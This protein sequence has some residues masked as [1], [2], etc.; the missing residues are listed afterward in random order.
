MSKLIATVALAA[1]IAMP[2]QGGVAVPS[3]TRNEPAIAVARPSVV[4]IELTYTG[5]VRD[6]VTGALRD[7]APVVFHRRCSGVVVNPRGNVVTTSACVRP[8]DDVVVATALETLSSTTGRNHPGAGQADG[9]RTDAKDN[10]AFTG[11]RAGTRPTVA[12][13]V[14]FDTAT[15]G[16]KSALSVPATVTATQLPTAGNVALLKLDGP[17]FP[18][19]EFGASRDPKPGDPLIVL[20]YGPGVSEQAAGKYTLRSKTVTVTNRTGTNRFGLSGDIGTDSQGGPV[21]DDDGRLVALVDVDSSL[22]DRPTHDLITMPHI[23][24][25]LDRSGVTNS[26]ADTDRGYRDGLAE[27]FAGQYSRAIDI[28]EALPAQPSNAARIY[29]DLSQQRLADEGNAIPN[30]AAWRQ[31]ALA[32]LLGV[33]IILLLGAVGSAVRLWARGRGRR[34]IPHREQESWIAR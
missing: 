15:P 3:Y 34:R 14:Q 31:Y 21:V 24:E 33:F 12:I 8:S 10:S 6:T 29:L 2:A 20:G 32:L 9:P 13:S 26:L 1:V 25:L 18:A 28:F 11:R 22:P 23:T 7:Q 19:I 27:Y 16:A 30:K 5:Y 4:Y 17:A